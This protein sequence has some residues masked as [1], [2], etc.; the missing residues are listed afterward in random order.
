VDYNCAG[1]GGRN[2][3]LPARSGTVI[4]RPL[5]WMRNQMEFRDYGK[6]ST[7]SNITFDVKDGVK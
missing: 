7:E 5:M 6:F 2:Y 3:L 1:V 4:R